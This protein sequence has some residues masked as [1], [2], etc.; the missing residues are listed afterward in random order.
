MKKNF[1][2]LIFFLGSFNVFTQGK[3]T[4]DKIGKETCKYFQKNKK[5][6]ESLSK[7][8]RIAKLGIK[9]LSLYDKYKV[10]LK[11]EGIEVDIS[12]DTSTEAFGQKVGISM[13]NHCLD[14][15]L[16]LSED[17][18]DNEEEVNFNVVGELKSISGDELS[19]VSL[20]DEN[21]KTQKFVWLNN[22]EGS[23]KLI[24]SKKNK[25]LKVKLSYINVELY[26]PKLKEYIVRKQI[27]KIEYLD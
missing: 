18:P 2:I 12:D 10:D 23:D 27:S 3:T 13:A 16:L 22:F 21:G 7:N 15:L 9:M 20:K 4:I 1:L 14:L 19:Y 26:S 5:E 25:N 6:L 24:N 17:F 8:E 11:A